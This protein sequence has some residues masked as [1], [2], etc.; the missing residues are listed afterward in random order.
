MTDNEEP[1]TLSVTEAAEK[2]G[3]TTRTL[4]RWIAIDQCPVEWIKIGGRYRILAKSM[5]EVLAA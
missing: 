5:K 4:R 1:L 3:V 2:I